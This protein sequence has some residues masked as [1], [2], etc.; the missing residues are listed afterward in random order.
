MKTIHKV[1]SVIRFGKSSSK[2]HLLFIPL[3][4]GFASCMKEAG[5]IYI[6][7]I[8][9]K[10]VVHSFISPQE[11]TLRVRVGKTLPLFNTQV[12]YYDWDEQFRVPNALV[13]ITG[14]DNNSITLAY[15]AQ[16]NTYMAPIAGF[17][18][19]AGKEYRI[20]V[21]APDL[22][23]VTGSCVVPP[24]NNS[25]VLLETRRE[26][27]SY[28][29]TNF[30]LKAR[31]TDIPNQENF[32]RFEAYKKIEYQGYEE[33]IFTNYF[34]MNLRIGEQFFSD[35][36]L[37]GTAFTFVSDYNEYSG[38][39]PLNDNFRL[40][41]LSTDEHYYR[42]HVTLNKHQSPNPFMEPTPLYSNMSNGIGIFAA[43]NKYSVDY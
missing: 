7:D 15:N 9:V 4:L 31:M 20:K 37:D 6:P 21:S 14:P 19:E 18:I 40:V 8:P 10:M 13:E 39:Y 42:Y 25:L 22:E 26:A 28:S 41:L 5:N 33:E 16:N 32:Y 38:G 23:T 34:G 35:K 17:S 1:L 30:I 29:G 2:I 11:D 43:F 3:F 36:N 27:D 24:L 12:N